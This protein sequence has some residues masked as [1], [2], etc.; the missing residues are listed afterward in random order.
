MAQ[1]VLY[2]QGPI[3]I[4]DKS[5]RRKATSSPYESQHLRVTDRDVKVSVLGTPATA[6]PRKHTQPS[7]VKAGSRTFRFVPSSVS[8]KRL[9]QQR[10]PP[11]KVKPK[12]ACRDNGAVIGLSNKSSSPDS[13]KSSSNSFDDVSLLYTIPLS[14]S[15]FYGRHEGFMPAAADVLAYYNDMTY[16]FYPLQPLLKLKFDPV[17]EVYLP[18]ALRDVCMLNALVTTTAYRMHGKLGWRGDSGAIFFSTAISEMQKRIAGGDITDAVIM[19]T[20]CFVLRDHCQGRADQSHT[21]VN[22]M[23]QMLEVRGGLG[24]VYPGFRQKIYRAL[25]GPAI[26]FLSVPR[27]P[28]PQHDRPSLYSTLKLSLPPNLTY[29]PLLSHANL[30][31]E[32]T[33]IMLRLNQLSQSINHCITNRTAIDPFALDQD[34]TT[35]QHDLLCL[36]TTH[37]SPSHPT[38]TTFPPLSQALILAALVF[39]RLLTR[40]LPLAL[41][42][43]EILPTAMTSLMGSIPLQ[44]PTLTLRFWCVFLGA[45]AARQTNRRLLLIGDLRGSCIALGLASWKAA[46][47]TLEQVAWI[48]EAFEGEGQRL[49][50][51]IDLEEM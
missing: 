5:L 41:L 13:V 38:P 6:K 33:E 45:L 36:H 9:Q 18:E 30:D 51:E 32:L 47:E 21:H 1:S 35:L 43:S 26:D 48:G 11:G 10:E 28:R 25:L 12:S 22:G 14:S 3:L 37:S 29:G 2:P 34:I 27:W 7:S 19:A 8:D 23:L 44:P 46:R 17:T 50:R 39:T 4:V 15:P 42:N 20:T 16:F 49:W 40:E 31:P 24:N